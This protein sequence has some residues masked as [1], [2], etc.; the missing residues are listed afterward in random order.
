MTVSN[1]KAISPIIAA[2]LLVVIVVGLGAA[3]MSIARNYL[4]EGKQDITEKKEEIKCGKDVGM[5]IVIIGNNYQI[6]NA[7]AEETD[8]ASLNVMLVNTGTIPIL[9]A[10]VRMVGT[11]GIF[12]NN[13]VFNETMEMGDT[14][15]LNITYDPESVG[16]FRQVFIVPRIKLP[17]I[18]Q[19]AFCS[20]VGI[21]AIEIP[22]NCTTFT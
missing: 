2:V 22:N 18:Q 1:R 17:G 5:E 7:T 16:E 9:D 20:D 12:M 11:R 21:E 15:Q 10:Q 13:S 14:I 6:C 8:M 3:L 19:H 4:S